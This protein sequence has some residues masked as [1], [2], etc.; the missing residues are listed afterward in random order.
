MLPRHAGIPDALTQ[1][2]ESM[3]TN[4]DFLTGMQAQLKSWDA[5]LDALV[6]DGKKAGGEARTA[7]DRRLKELRLSRK[8]AQKSLDELRAATGSATVQMQA[9]MTLVWETMQKAMQKVSSDLKGPATAVA[10]Q[11]EQT[12]PHHEPRTD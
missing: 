1:R 12:A 3:N 10:P 8:A 9:G 4:S 5:N 11:A 7:Y 6:A 2:I